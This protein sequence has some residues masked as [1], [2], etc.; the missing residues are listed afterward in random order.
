MNRLTQPERKKI[1]N[2]YVTPNT[3]PI[4]VWLLLKSVWVAQAVKVGG[5]GERVFYGDKDYEILLLTNRTV[6][7]RTRGRKSEAHVYVPLENIRSFEALNDTSAHDRIK[8]ASA[9]S[10][11]GVGEEGEDNSAD[12]G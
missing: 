1:A 4:G 11:A 9:A 7:I 12:A 2:K 6:K 5:D 10:T 8:A 3:I